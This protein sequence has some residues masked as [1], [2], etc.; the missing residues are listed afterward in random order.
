ML[1]SHS[2]KGYL[3]ILLV[4]VS[5]IFISWFSHINRVDAY[6]ILEKEY[7]DEFAVVSVKIQYPLNNEIIDK[8]Y[9][10]FEL[11]SKNSYLKSLGKFAPV[12]SI[13][14]ELL[15]SRG[16]DE[17]FINIL[18]CESQFNIEAKSIANAVGLWQFMPDTARQVGLKLH[19]VDERKDI[20]A[21]TIAF[22]KHFSY[23][24]KKY[25]NLELAVAAY[26]CGVG[27][28]D[29]II[30]RNKSR[31]FWDLRE[32]GAFPKETSAYVPKFLAI[33][34]WSSK[35]Q[36]LIDNIVNDVDNTYYI[37][38]MNIYSKKVVNLIRTV[39]NDRQLVAKY[40]KHLKHLSSDK[41]DYSVNIFLDQE[42]LEYLVSNLSVDDEHNE[43][44][45]ASIL[46]IDFPLEKKR[47]LESILLK[48]GNSLTSQ[49]SIMPVVISAPF[50]K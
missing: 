40:N 36:I 42:G 44:A 12:Y 14:R 45:V 33:S 10:D 39:M 25:N 48:S 13:I 31:N 21:S 20:Y 17:Q 23:L 22:M 24:Y 16:F 6:S 7:S 46:Q 11:Y 26:N 1:I 4:V 9:K 47:T 15:K 34:K 30:S 19:E 43:K 37:V 35:N 32:K 41:F 28:V 38:R 29:S 49:V 2:K 8:Y 50:Y 27:K 18:W 5:T 3:I